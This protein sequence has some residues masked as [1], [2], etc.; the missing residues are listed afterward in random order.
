MHT[1]PED[2]HDL[3]EDHTQAFAVLGTTMD[4]HSPQVTP[5]W[6]NHDGE[7]ILINSAVGRV[8]DRNIR[9]RPRISLILWNLKDPE[10]YVQIRGEV[11]EI[12]TEGAD[13]HINQ[14]S[15]KYRGR[16]FV[17]SPGQQRVIYKIKP[18]SVFAED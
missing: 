2:F 11:V 10:R 4:D 16:D 3:L 13:E 17:F 15:H 1:I 18:D 8:K 12:I 7:H 5:V 6:F 14:L 9:Q